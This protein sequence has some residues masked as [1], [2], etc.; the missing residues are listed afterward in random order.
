M[1]TYIIFKR[2][3]GE[4]VHVH[5]EADDVATPPEEI[6]ELVDP[7]H[8]RGALEVTM[9]EP[10]RLRHGVAHRVHP[11]TRRLEAV[12]EA[13]FGGAS[14]SS[15]AGSRPLPPGVRTVYELEHPEAKREPRRGDEQS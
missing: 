13:S 8:D 12:E 6:L 11:Q 15:I 10:T 4:V 7:A 1:P 9:A 5:N 2:D 3:S 14:A